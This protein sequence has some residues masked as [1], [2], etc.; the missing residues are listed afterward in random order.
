MTLRYRLQAVTSCV[1][2]LAVFFYKRKYLISKDKQSSVNHPASKSADQL[3]SAAGVGRERTLFFFGFIN[4]K[5]LMRTYVL[6]SYFQVYL[7]GGSGVARTKKRVKLN[8]GTFTA[9]CCPI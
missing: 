2:S 3:E 5:T 6:G 8:P 1:P 4:K 9:S 7:G